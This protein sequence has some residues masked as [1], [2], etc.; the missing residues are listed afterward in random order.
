MPT[1][2]ESQTNTSDGLAISFDPDLLLLAFY[3]IIYVDSPLD[4]LPDPKDL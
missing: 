4:C 2:A 1:N 3:H